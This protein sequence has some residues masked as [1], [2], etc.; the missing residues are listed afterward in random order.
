MGYPARDAEAAIL[1]SQGEPTASVEALSPVATALDVAEAAALVAGV[2]VA[3]EVR[4]Y[5]LDIVGASR[6]HP[7]LVLGA[8]PRGALALQRAAR[9]LAAS[10]GRSYVLPD[11]VK[12]VMPS[13]LEHRLLVAPDAQ[14]RGVSAAD[15]VRSIVT[16][17]PVPGATGG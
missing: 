13:V 16:S 2:H 14:L 8:S 6:R 17:V 15:V 5:V 3:V 7:D 4:D 9:A 12:R 10:F 1:D 11:D